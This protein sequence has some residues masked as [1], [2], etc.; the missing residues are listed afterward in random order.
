MV[1]TNATAD[2]PT[3]RPTNLLLLPLC[4]PEL[5]RLDVGGDGPAAGGAPEGERHVTGG[6]AVDRDRDDVRRQH[7]EHVV[8]ENEESVSL[9][10][11][12]IA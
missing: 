7:D 8:P 6:H 5:L 1:G 4:P 3:D 2:R 10:L 12:F 9:C 11:K